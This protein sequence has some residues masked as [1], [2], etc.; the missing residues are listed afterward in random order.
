MLCH[1]ER[2]RER[3]RERDVM[4]SVRTVRSAVEGREERDLPRFRYGR[5]FVRSVFSRFTPREKCVPGEP[6]EVFTSKMI[7]S[8]FER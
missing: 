7:I 2:E 1:R 3:E 4:G 5:F 6:I 8:N